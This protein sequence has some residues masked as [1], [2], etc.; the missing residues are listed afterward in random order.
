MYFTTKSRAFI[1]AAVPKELMEVAD[2]CSYITLAE[3]RCHHPQ[4]SYP[5]PLWL[6]V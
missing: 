2:Q 4:H 3:R 6:L 1:Y 5:H